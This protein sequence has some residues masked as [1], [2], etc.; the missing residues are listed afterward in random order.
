MYRIAVRWRR[1][2]DTHVAC[3]HQRE[4]KCARN[5]RCRHRKRI[6]IGLQ[7]AQ[8]LFGGYA[9]LLFFV[10]DQETQIVPLHVLSYQLVRANQDVYL[11]FGKV[12]QHL[13]CLLCR[14]CP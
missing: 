2:N 12:G 10:N 14:P 6:D 11:T 4:L 13:F 3:A 8:F 9:E 1:S 5:R 7:S